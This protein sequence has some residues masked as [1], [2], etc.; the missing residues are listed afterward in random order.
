[1]NRLPPWRE[2]L[3]LERS[4]PDWL[5]GIEIGRDDEPPP[6]REEIWEQR[7]RRLHM[8]S[9][10]PSVNLL[11]PFRVEAGENRGRRP[12]AVEGAVV[13]EDHVLG[14]ERLAVMELDALPNAYCPH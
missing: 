12:L 4:S 3:E 14:A 1:E 6:N 5:R 7:E 13:R 10:R 11:D 8:D 2:R 9:H